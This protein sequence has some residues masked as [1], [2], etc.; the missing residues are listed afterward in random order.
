MIIENIYSRNLNFAIK[1]SITDSKDIANTIYLNA[2]LLD[3]FQ[4]DVLWKKLRGYMYVGYNEL[5]NIEVYNNKDQVIMDTSTLNVNNK[6]LLDSITDNDYKFVIE[7]SKGVHYISVGYKVNVGEQSFKII[8]TNDVEHLWEAKL[9]NY[10]VF[11]LLSLMT[12]IV[13][14]IGLFIISKRITNPIEDLSEIS[15]S[16]KNGDYEKRSTY[17]SK[18]EVGVLAEN[19][20][21]M[22]GVIEDNIRELEDVNDRK[23][24]FIDNLTHEMKTPI[25]SI[26]G[27][28]ELLLKGNLNE[29]MKIKALTNINEQGKRL[30]HLSDSLIKL[31][32]IRN[33]VIVKE[34]LKATEVINE[35]YS[36]NLFK[37][38][39]KHIKIIKDVKMGSIFGN[40]ELI[41]VL[42]N[43][44]I[45]NGIKA[46]NEEGVIA[47]VGRPVKE[48]NIYELKVKDN[49]S[50]IPK[51]ELKKINEPFYM[52]DKARATKGK[53]MGLGLAICTEI[54]RINNIEMSFNSKVDTG[55]I[56]TLKFKMENKIYES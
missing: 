36:N 8:V 11:I 9:Y 18:D 31:V 51:D 20:N 53:N 50:G 21:S 47:I 17:K 41:E 5:K 14:A 25:T 44:I 15:N 49:G 26:L 10:K 16:I 33:S 46:C 42:L 27:F 23:Q 38:R 24:R 32:L 39:T 12:T 55:T 52:V 2:D 3:K 29:E 56:V 48:K 34:N 37:I 4:G 45:D 30:E 54:C 28:S 22:M 6:E 43:N 19:F 13:L 1:N 40:K 35:I 7:E